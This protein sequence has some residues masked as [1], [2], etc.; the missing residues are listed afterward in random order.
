V[1]GASGRQAAVASS[2]N[3]DRRDGFFIALTKRPLS[4]TLRY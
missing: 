4:D 1:V 2:S 3:T